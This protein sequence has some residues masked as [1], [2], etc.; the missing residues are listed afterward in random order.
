MALGWCWSGGRRCLKRECVYRRCG[1]VFVVRV[2]G[3]FLNELVAWTG[4]FGYR[5]V[6]LGAV[7]AANGKEMNVSGSM[8][9]LLNFSE[10]EC[11][12]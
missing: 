3:W 12:M 1:L 5:D 10:I 4:V 8:T 6:Q 11:C 7:N 2:K 9:F